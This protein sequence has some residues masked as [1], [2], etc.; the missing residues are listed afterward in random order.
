M[1]I[2]AIRHIKGESAASQSGFMTD[3]EIRCPIAGCSVAYSID[4]TPEETAISVGELRTK[5]TPKVT[6]SHPDHPDVIILKSNP[7][8]GSLGRNAA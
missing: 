5:A 6:G 7:H 4:Y 1:T 3:L 8:G 2:R